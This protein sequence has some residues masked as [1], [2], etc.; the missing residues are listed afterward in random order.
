MPE[1]FPEATIRKRASA[2]DR[3]ISE[4]KPTD[5]RVRILGT[6]IDKQEDKI[7]VDDGSGKIEIGFDE[8]VNAEINQ[9]VRIF[10]RVM[11][12]ENGTEL[13]G[14]IIQDMSKIDRGILAKI[15]EIKQKL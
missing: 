5:T 9:F 8:P 10:G 1:D 4:I 12:V 6:V 3:K 13:Q 11:P 14:E 15:E 2:V 7:V